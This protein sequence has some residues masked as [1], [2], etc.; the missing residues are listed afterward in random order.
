MVV[1]AICKIVRIIILGVEDAHVHE[2]HGISNKSTPCSMSEPTR[3][4]V[5]ISEDQG[6]GLFS[7][8]ICNVTVSSGLYAAK[9]SFLHNYYLW[10]V[11][12]RAC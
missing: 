3:T 7:C 4:G 11:L 10:R 5:D 2:V 9:L 8:T 1:R 6:V 12:Q